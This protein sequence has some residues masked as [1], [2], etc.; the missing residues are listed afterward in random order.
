MNEAEV[1]Q[2]LKLVMDPEV[3]I[4]IVDLGLVYAVELEPETVN[5]QMTMT[6]PTCPLHA[7]VTRNAEE[8]IRANIKQA[9]AVNI[10]LVW[11]PP[12]EPGMMSSEA[13]QI[14]GW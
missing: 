7:V 4:N 1:R 14:L 9:R 3:G 10:E 8:T 11:D 2:T 6:S 12:W 13:K 5:I